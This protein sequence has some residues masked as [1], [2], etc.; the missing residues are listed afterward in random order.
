L[1][2]A[3]YTRDLPS[4]AFTE[5]ALAEACPRELQS[6]RRVLCPAQSPACLAQ[7]PAHAM[8][9]RALK[10][11]GERITRARNATQGMA[12]FVP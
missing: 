3:E 10:R 2:T 7:Q 8:R 6:G 1:L 12:C 11:R 9:A 5:S 4:G